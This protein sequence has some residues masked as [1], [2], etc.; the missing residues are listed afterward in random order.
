MWPSHGNGV[1]IRGFLIE[2]PTAQ[3][4]QTVTGLVQVGLGGT[5]MTWE[6]TEVRG[7]VV[8]SAGRVRDKVTGTWA[9]KRSCISRRYRDKHRERRRNR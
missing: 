3:V 4:K 6:S 5:T 7:S 8:G 1:Q 9:E 2:I